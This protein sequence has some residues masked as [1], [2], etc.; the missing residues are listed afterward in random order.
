MST[1]ALLARAVRSAVGDDIGLRA[2]VGLGLKRPCREGADQ[3]LIRD[4][5][6]QGSSDRDQG[7][8]QQGSRDQRMRIQG[9][10]GAEGS[11]GV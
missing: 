5:E 8:V 9:S 11:C 10:M 7:T 1:P 3:L 4:P 6:I 2:P